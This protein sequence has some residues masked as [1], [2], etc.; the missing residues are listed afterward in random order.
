MK[1]LDFFFVPLLLGGCFLTGDFPLPPHL[2]VWATVTKLLETSRAHRRDTSVPSACLLSLHFLL[3]WHPS[4]ILLA[5]CSSHFYT[6]A[7][8]LRRA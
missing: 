8:G 2:L 6:K 1:S 3:P 5:R 4:A 7:N